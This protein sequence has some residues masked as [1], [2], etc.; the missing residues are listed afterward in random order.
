MK[1]WIDFLEEGKL[2][3]DDAVAKQITL[4]ADKYGMIDGT[5]Y[6]FYESR[7]PGVTE[8]K[9]V[10]KQLVVPRGRRAELIRHYHHHNGHPGL[11]RLYDN[12]KNR[13]YW[14]RQTYMRCV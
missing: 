10:I 13:Y 14:P 5:L 12:L 11:Q 6:H 9:G 8:V 1:L 7:N 3:L 4:T 2:P